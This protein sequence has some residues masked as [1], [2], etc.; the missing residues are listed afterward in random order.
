MGTNKQQVRF[1][2]RFRGY[3]SY[4]N[5][6]IQPD[7]LIPDPGNSGD[8]NRYAYVNYNPINFNDPT[9]HYSSSDNPNDELLK[10]SSY[11]TNYYSGYHRDIVAR[12]V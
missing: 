6:F 3:G 7:T 12:E 11:W 4:L 2:R 8:W 9:G 1:V 10:D 5:Q